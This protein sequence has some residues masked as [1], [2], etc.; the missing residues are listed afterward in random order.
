MGKL[1]RK[2]LREK[3]HLRIRRKIIGTR[4]VPRMSVCITSKHLYV[5]FIDDEAGKTL[6]YI[7]TLAKNLREENIKA[8]CSGA[9]KI[10]RLAA[11]V[12]LD[13]GIKKVVFDRAGFKYHGRI[14]KIADSAREVGLIF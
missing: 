4:L 11:E 2:Q 12:A 9:E 3:R 14:K 1:S 8:N 13:L 6:S 10:G 7:S 5:Q